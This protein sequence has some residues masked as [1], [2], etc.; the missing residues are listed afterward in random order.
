MGTPIYKTITS[1]ASPVEAGVEGAASPAHPALLSLTHPATHL[2]G[3]WAP[4]STGPLHFTP[5]QTSPTAEKLARKLDPPMGL[6]SEQFPCP[7]AHR[8][9]P[10]SF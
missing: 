10:Y 1:R 4:W 8:I 2:P 6:T 9:K 3:P 7:A 5:S